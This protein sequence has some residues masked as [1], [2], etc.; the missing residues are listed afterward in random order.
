[1]AGK[2][3]TKEFEGE[4]RRGVG[5]VAEEMK[6]KIDNAVHRG[7]AFQLWAARLLVQADRGLETDTEEALLQFHDLMPR[8]RKKARSS[9]RTASCTDSVTMR[10][11]W[12]ACTHV[13]WPI[14]G[15]LYP[16]ESE[17]RLHSGKH[18][19]QSHASC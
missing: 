6:W 19:G 12:P 18:F 14:L 7:Y 13:Q 11:H 4:I 10:L 8:A 1:M 2:L 5:Q 15:K 17:A 9:P 16:R 3:S